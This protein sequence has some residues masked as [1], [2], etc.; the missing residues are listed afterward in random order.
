MDLSRRDFL[1]GLS[2]AAAEASCVKAD[3]SC[4]APEVPYGGAPPQPL[5]GVGLTAVRETMYSFNEVERATPTVYTPASEADVAALLQAASRTHRRVTFRG[6][7]QSLDDQSLNNDLVLLMTD[8][9]FTKI[10]DPQPSDEGFYIDVGAGARWEDVIRHVGAFGLLPPSFATAQCATVGGTMSADCL[11]RMSCVFGKE[12][13]QIRAFTVVL[14]TGE[15]VRC[16][17]NQGGALGRLFH[18]VV[19]GFGFLGA[20]TH[21]SFDLVAARRAPPPLTRGA[22]PCVFTRSTRSHP[23]TNWDTALR[24]L[25]SKTVAAKRSYE[26]HAHHHRGLG[27]LDPDLARA[28]EWTGLSLAAFL[29]GSGLSA[30]LLQQ[31]YLDPQALN[32]YPGGLYEAKN[33]FPGV[34]E[35]ANVNWPTVVDVGVDFNPEGDYVDDLLGWGFFLGYSTAVAKNAAHATKDTINF[36]QQ[37]FAL[38]AGTDAAVD[39]RETR[40]FIELVIARLHAADLQPPVLDF[41]YVPSDE[42]TMSASRGLISFVATVSFTEHNRKGEFSSE[43]V[44][45]LHALSNDCRTLGGR[46]HLVKG[47]KADPGDLRAMYGDAAREFL[48]LK[49]LCDPHDVLRNNFFER[50]L[51]A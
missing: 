24:E 35:L 45:T 40:R 12:S 28:P 29:A 41:L 39:T 1:A 6:G 42:F 22:L 7:G 46:V 49:K 37:S 44:D 50:V 4:W 34:A 47:V 13:Q 15:T 14:P 25:Q 2:I 27:K 18:A 10:G 36:T 17:R 3:N 48:A 30:T 32:P 26:R 11:S 21:V 33:T 5:P 8:P 31:R 43:L 16:R 19:G 38:P 20:V 9:A 51:L 23:S